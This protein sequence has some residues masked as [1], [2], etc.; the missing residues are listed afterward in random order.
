MIPNAHE[1]SRILVVDDEKI[2][3]MHLEELLTNMGYDVVDTASNGAEAIQRMRDDLGLDVDAT[4]AGGEKE[5]LSTRQ[6]EQD[7]LTSR[8][9]KITQTNVGITVKDPN[10][11]TDVDV[12]GEPIP[13]MTSSTMGIAQ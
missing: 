7:G 5:A 2:I 3:T 8:L 1:K 9:E 4:G 10:D 12:S 13:V 6:A 11:R